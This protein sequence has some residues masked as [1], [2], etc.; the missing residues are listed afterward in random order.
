MFRWFARLGLGQK[1]MISLAGIMGLFYTFNI[2]FSLQ[3]A[4]EQAIEQM[5]AFAGGIAETV[6]SSLNTMMVQ[7]TIGERESFFK[8]MKSTTSGLEDIR[9]FRSKSLAEQY[10]GGTAE[11]HPRDGMEKRI[12]ETGV[13]EYT[14]E[15]K[16][17]RRVFRAVVPF[18]MSENRGGSINCMDC[19]EGKAGSVNGGVSMTI[20]MEAI[21]HRRN[22]DAAWMIGSLVVELGAIMGMVAFL[23]SRNITRP[24]RLTMGR[25]IE[26]AE[27]VDS[28][29]SNVAEA[30]QYIADSATK[31]AAALEQTTASVQTISEMTAHN[32]TDADNVNT[33]V[34]SMKTESESGSTL[35]KELLDTMGRIKNLSGGSRDLAENGKRDVGEMTEAMKSLL[36]STERISKIIKAIDEIAF[37]TNLLALN[38]A[39]EAARAGRAGKG[40]AVVAEEVR[41]LAG[42]SAEAAKETSTIIDEVVDRIGK[43]NSVA[44]KAGA[45]LGNIIASVQNVAKAVEDGN[46]TAQKAGMALDG[47][48]KNVSEVATLVENITNASQDQ[49][50]NVKQVNLA[51]RHMDDVTQQNAATAEETAASAQQLKEQAKIF[52]TIV[53]E[54]VDVVEGSKAKPAPPGGSRKTGDNN[55]LEENV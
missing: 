48:N 4:E 2:L 49:A 21:D 23:A 5:D 13:K 6:L 38:A 42:R 43:G 35:M 20:S 12:L 24:L 7:G 14:V 16:D 53:R 54:L 55:W 26:S 27:S 18:I 15:K 11:E 44:V 47:I 19:H 36:V 34:I 33:H 31:Q 28:A 3:R 25:L 41:N 30:S 50:A 39:V 29:A 45:T 40:F 46:L 10:G 8:L 51:I 32:A 37:Q 9:V 22:V 52:E 17:G 1:L